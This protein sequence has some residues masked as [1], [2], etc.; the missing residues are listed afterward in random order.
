MLVQVEEQQAS[1]HDK[2]ISDLKKQNETDMLEVLHKHREELAS[3]V[4]SEKT[5]LSAMHK[6]QIAQLE[7]QVSL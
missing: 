5:S 2:N 4:T 3:M 7:E 1:A 6:N